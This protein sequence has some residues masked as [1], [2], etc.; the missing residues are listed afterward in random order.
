M[1]WAQ[2][3][4]SSQLLIP[5]TLMGTRLNF[6]ICVLYTQCHA[7]PP[8]KKMFL[9]FWFI[10]RVLEFFSACWIFLGLL[11]VHFNSWQ[12]FC[13]CYS[14]LF[15]DQWF[16][17]FSSFWSPC[18]APNSQIKMTPLAQVCFFLMKVWE[19]RESTKLLENWR[20]DIPTPPMVPL[21]LNNCRN[22]VCFP[23]IFPQSSLWKRLWMPLLFSFINLNEKW[24]NKKK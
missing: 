11:W 22:I 16:L 10:L 14:N 21:E 20:Q 4:W 5:I 6:H 7:P 12:W 18:N 8:T 23:G 15:I 24:K 9:R 17:T 2:Y 13:S 3:L 19:F 1:T